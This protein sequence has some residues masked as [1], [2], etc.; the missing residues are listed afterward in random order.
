MPKS[1]S[2]SCCDTPNQTVAQ[3]VGEIGLNDVERF[4]R[5]IVSSSNLA[6]FQWSQF[7][8]IQNVPAVALHLLFFLTHLNDRFD[9]A[10]LWTDHEQHPFMLRVSFKECGIILFI[11]SLLDRCI[12]AF[13]IINFF[14]DKRGDSLSAICSHFARHPPKYTT[15]IPR[16][17]CL[18]HFDVRAEFGSFPHLNSIAFINKLSEG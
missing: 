2:I 4:R 12:A 9:F 10:I 13:A 1:T 6:A 5:G 16:P 15:G 17:L 14:I 11:Y 18:F 7:P 8:E 3:A